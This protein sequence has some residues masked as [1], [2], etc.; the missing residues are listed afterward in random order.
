MVSYPIIAPLCVLESKFRSYAI[1]IFYP[2]SECDKRSSS[3]SMPRSATPTQPEIPDGYRRLGN[4][5]AYRKENDL[6]VI[7]ALDVDVR[8]PDIEAMLNIYEKHKK[9]LGYLLVLIDGKRGGSMTPEARKRIAE[10]IRPEVLHTAS[11]IYNINFTG[12]VI[13]NLIFK[14]TVLLSKLPHGPMEFFDTEAEAR[15]FL[16]RFRPKSSK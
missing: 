5:Y 12:R 11:A 13:S 15:A 14:A 9:E 4:A 6:L 2:S 3:I 7:I 16:D 8:G 10:L 1:S